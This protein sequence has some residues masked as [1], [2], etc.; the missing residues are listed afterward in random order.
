[1]SIGWAQLK[2]HSPKFSMRFIN[3]LSPL[4]CHWVFAVEVTQDCASVTHQDLDKTT[5]FRMVYPRQILPHKIISTQNY[6]SGSYIRLSCIATGQSVKGLVLSAQS[7]KHK[8]VMAADIHISSLTLVLFR[9]Q[10]HDKAIRLSYNI[11]VISKSRCSVSM[12]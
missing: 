9:S 11:L 3:C 1:M 4:K 7:G 5:V 10:S 12:W 8:R 6:P 2:W